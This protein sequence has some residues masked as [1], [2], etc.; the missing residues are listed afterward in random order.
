MELPMQFYNFLLVKIVGKGAS[1]KVYEAYDV[2]DGKRVAIK[3]FRV[4]SPDIALSEFYT[5]TYLSRCLDPRTGYVV[6]IYNAGKYDVKNSLNEEY[7]EAVKEVS[8]TMLG[9]NPGLYRGN[10]YFIVQELMDINLAALI[11][12]FNQNEAAWRKFYVENATYLIEELLRGLRDIHQAHIA[13]QDIKPENILLKLKND[14]I[15]LTECLISL[16]CMEAN[17]LIKYADLGIA[18]SNLIDKIQNC[19]AGAGT[20]DFMAPEDVRK[21]RLDTHQTQAKDLWSLGMT[22]YEL[23]FGENLLFPEAE[24]TGISYVLYTLQSITQE[25]IDNKLDAKEME[26]LFR[27]IFRGL[28]QVNPDNRQ[29]ASKILETFFE[30]EEVT[31][32][33]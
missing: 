2:K 21:D 9:V 5:N 27:D 24:D 26:P 13:H 8:E 32:F 25:D 16:E 20:L 14:D 31:I 3:L 1:G 11:G 6:C 18:C 12:F 17:V 7:R 4:S 15:S 33:L 22:I 10:D 28:L 19:Q 23:L 30:D 29:S